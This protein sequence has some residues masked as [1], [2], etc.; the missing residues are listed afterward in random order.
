MTEH[1]EFTPSEEGGLVCKS[2]ED[3]IRIVRAEDDPSSSDVHVHIRGSE[4]FTRRHEGA[5][6]FAQ[7]IYAEALGESVVSGTAK[8]AK[9]RWRFTPENIATLEAR[10][11]LWAEKKLRLLGR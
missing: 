3:T 6:P 4:T 10:V 1:L 5:Q 8:V 11:R 2:D 7:R 9:E